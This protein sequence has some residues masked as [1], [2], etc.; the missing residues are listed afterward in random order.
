MKREQYPF[1]A[2]IGQEAM[3][4]ALLL[5]AIDPTIGGL[6]IRGQKGTGKSTAV[7]ALA[8]L[9]PEIDVVAGCPYNSSPD[10]P[11][12]MSHE[13]RE[14]FQRGESLPRVKR[15]MPLVELPLNTTEDRLV[16]A[17]HL[18]QTLRT[19]RREFEPGLLASANRGILYVDEVNL[20]EDHLVDMLLDVASSGINI[21]E[22][23]NI[24][25]AHPAHFI[26]IGSMNPEEGTLRP[27]FLD[28][29]GLCVNI[30][31]IQDLHKR[32]EIIRYRLA[33]DENPK[34]FRAQWATEQELLAGQIVY[35]RSQLRQ[36]QISEEIF[37][38]TARLAGELEVH[39][40]RADIAI[41]KTARALA[42]FLERPSVEPEHLAAAT[43]LVMP[44]RIQEGPLDNYDTLRCKIDK[45]L[46]KCFPA[47]LSTGNPDII[48]D[49]QESVRESVYIAP[50]PSAEGECMS[51]LSENMQ[52]PGSMAAG[53]LDLVS[54]LKKK[55]KN[56]SLTPTP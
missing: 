36:V 50:L 7:R 9:L 17:L 52:V 5:N 29:F 18:E 34:T 2:M 28:R 46:A 40:H 21:I 47:G 30:Q 31:G 15:P 54:F 33:F 20:L 1:S 43:H 22:H 8:E 55:A 41:V 26:L 44:H 48:L 19:G 53:S 6:L 3:K 45:V 35:A 42:A 39:G 27:Q 24:S 14:R 10:D 37:T 32:Q 16:G 51:E 23:E 12:Y 56:K 11:E 13:C 38:M 4:T 25:Y 49:P